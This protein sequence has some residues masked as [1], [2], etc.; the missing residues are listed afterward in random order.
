G[1][2]VKTV[3]SREDD[4]RGGFYR[5]AFLHRIEAGVNGKGEPVAGKHT[6]VGQ[7]ILAG[8]PLEKMMVHEGIDGASVE[9]VVDSPYLE[10]VPAKQITLHSPKSEVT[11]LWWRSVG[12]THTAFAME[13][14]IDELA[15]AAGREPLE[16]RLALL[17]RKPRHARALK[18]AAEK[19][20]W[21]TKL[22]PRHARGLAMQESSRSIIAEVGE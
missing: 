16:F 11:V 2:P 3:W 8:T 22:P 1:V 13:S 18:T 19:A 7:S 21:G 20:G 15:H 12:N 17:A 10:D 14:M 4:I 9:G 5:P 6:I